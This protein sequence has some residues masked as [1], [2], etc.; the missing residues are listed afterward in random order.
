MSSENYIT[1][2]GQ[3]S[4]GPR[5][6][7]RG[8]V[9]VLLEVEEDPRFLR[10]G[11]N[12]VHELPITFSQ[13]ALGDQLEVPT[14]EG[15]AKLNVPAGVQ[16]GSVLYVKAGVDHR[17]HSITEDLSVLVLFSSAGGAAL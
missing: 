5:G 16:S 10:D 4:V 14:V 6:G 7:P 1:L 8:D 3:G 13:A 2:R 17:F 11:S 9:V 12:L 15:T